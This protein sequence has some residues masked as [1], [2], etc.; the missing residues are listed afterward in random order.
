MRTQARA[1]DETD[2]GV[3]SLLARLQLAAIGRAGGRLAHRSLPTS[4][5]P[6]LGTGFPAASTTL[7]G[8]FTHGLHLDLEPDRVAGADGK[9]RQPVAGLWNRAEAGSRTSGGISTFLD[10]IETAVTRSV[11]TPGTGKMRAFT[12]G[13]P[14]PVT[15]LI[16]RPSTTCAAGAADVSTQTIS[17]ARHMRISLRYV[18]A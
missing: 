11:G 7:P 14:P 13:I 3:F 4:Q 5:T 1:G 18:V 8:E 2:D 12:P 15:A 16:T 9:R 6:A 10:A 17:I